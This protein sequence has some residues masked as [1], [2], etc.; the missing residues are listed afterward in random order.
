MTNS[1]DAQREAFLKSLRVNN[2]S[3][4]NSNS[5]AKRAQFANN[6]SNNSSKGEAP[7]RQRSLDRGRG[8]ER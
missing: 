8:Y 1:S 2:T 7:V 3:K 6:N 5:Q 4:N